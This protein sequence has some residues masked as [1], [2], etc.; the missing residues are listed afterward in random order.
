MGEGL[1]KIHNFKFDLSKISDLKI[2][3]IYIA[4][5][6]QSLLPILLAK[7]SMYSDGS[8]MGIPRMFSRRISFK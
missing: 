1:F 3:N 5:N 6:K 2:E 8:I 7:R 4:G